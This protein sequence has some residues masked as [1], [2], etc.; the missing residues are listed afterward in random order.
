[1]GAARGTRERP[2]A[3]LYQNRDG[4]GRLPRVQALLDRRR[5][6][7]ALRNAVRAGSL[8]GLSGLRCLLL[9]DWRGGCDGRWLHA[10]LRAG[11]FRSEALAPSAAKRLAVTWSGVRFWYR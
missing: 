2:R 9:H 3:W 8:R 7:A 5:A 1:M 6:D 4:R 10:V 11:K